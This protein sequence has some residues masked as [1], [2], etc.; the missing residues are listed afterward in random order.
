MEKPRGIVLR[1][2]LPNVH[3]CVIFDQLIG[4]FDATAPKGLQNLAPG[5]LVSYQR[6]AQYNQYKL[7]VIELIAVPVCISHETIYFLHHVLE[8]CYFFL[9]HESSNESLFCLLE[10]LL[11]AADF[12][13]YSWFKKIFLL[14]F[15][16]SVGMYPE[17]EML[18]TQ[19]IREL[20]EGPIIL[21]DHMLDSHTNQALTKWLR[22]CIAMHPQKHLFKTLAIGSTYALLE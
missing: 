21:Q 16:I 14:R 3:K 19:R 13:K 5:F 7:E 20:I 22:D 6:I 17:D 15:F 10:F 2:Y 11:H 4:K 1:A 8:L 18:H 12:I 9:P